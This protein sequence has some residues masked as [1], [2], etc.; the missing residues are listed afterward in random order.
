M[1][2]CVCVC[3]DIVTVLCIDSKGKSMLCDLSL[4]HCQ[5]LFFTGFVINSV[6]FSLYLKINKSLSTS[7]ALQI[8]WLTFW[9]C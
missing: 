3:V 9:S 8:S 6:R 1:C 2:V 7:V 4:C 5:F